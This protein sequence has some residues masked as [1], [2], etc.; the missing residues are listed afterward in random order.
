MR[1]KTEAGSTIPVGAVVPF[2]RNFA[3]RSDGIIV[4]ALDELEYMENELSLAEAAFLQ[5]PSFDGFVIHHLGSYRTFMAS[6]KT[7]R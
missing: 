5:H 1:M 7:V 4:H 6:P 2:Y 3:V